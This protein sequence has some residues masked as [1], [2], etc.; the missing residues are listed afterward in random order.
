MKGIT[1]KQLRT[2]CNKAI[3]EGNGDKTILISSDDEGNSYHTLYYEF[4]TDKKII[5]ELHNYGLFHD[6]NNSDDIVI[7]G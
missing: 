2:F 1:V 7:L 3:K 4:I 5:D 6:N